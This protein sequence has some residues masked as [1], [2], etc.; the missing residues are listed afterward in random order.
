MT[1][2]K[3]I[4]WLALTV[5]SLPIALQA[6][7]LV[8]ATSEDINQFD[9]MLAHSRRDVP[10]ARKTATLPR[11]AQIGAA[12]SAEA[13]KL[14]ESTVSS[15]RALGRD[16]NGHSESGSAPSGGSTSGTGS[17]FSGGRGNT[18]FGG[19]ATTSLQP[20]EGHSHGGHGHGHGHH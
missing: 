16:T 8:P 7:M 1:S 12:V 11:A 10:E 15:A 9:N 19:S 3:Y 20:G 18:P 2:K 17:T 6:E 4:L 5:L 13:K 14:R